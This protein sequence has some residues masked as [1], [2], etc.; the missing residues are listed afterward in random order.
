MIESFQANPLAFIGAAAFTA[1][2]VIIVL[3]AIGEKA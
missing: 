2:L 1:V 3:S